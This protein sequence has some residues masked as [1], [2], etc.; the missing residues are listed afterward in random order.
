MA[1]AALDAPRK[2]QQHL[3]ACRTRSRLFNFEQ[4]KALVRPLKFGK[5]ADFHVWAKSC[6]RPL[7][8]P[9]A[10]DKFYRGRGWV[11]W[12]DALGYY[13]PSRI[14]RAEKAE[15]EPLRKEPR[16][17]NYEEALAW[18]MST[19]AEHASDYEVRRLPRK[20]QGS[21]FVRR[22][23][24]KPN[25]GVE[26]LWKIFLVKSAASKAIRA[27][28]YN[29]AAR[30]FPS[31]IGVIACCGR[32]GRAEVLSAA[33]LDVKLGSSPSSAQARF[34]LYHL[35]PMDTERGADSQF[36]SQFREVFA[37]LPEKSEADWLGQLAATDAYR[38]MHL[39]YREFVRDL[40][41]PAGVDFEV[42]GGFRQVY[43]LLLRKQNCFVT[44][45]R[46]H[47]STGKA[48]GRISR[49]RWCDP[50]RGLLPLDACDG[51]ELAF[52]VVLVWRQP[53]SLIGAYVFPRSWLLRNKIVRSV[54]SPGRI[55]ITL[56]PL[57]TAVRY[58]SCKRFYEDQ[59]RYYID[60][61]SRAECEVG[62]RCK[63]F[64]EILDREESDETTK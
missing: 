44:T 23:C 21:L 32:E 15:S 48:H 62:E 61:Q 36:L 60:F 24:C 6:K 64:R 27:S 43:N 28:Y 20:M 37:Q 14:R 54:S 3:S 5:R 7:R 4:F 42:I 49:T 8:I 26:S 1:L 35:A 16:S 46:I 11:S 9:L 25:E 31:D 10:P 55:S 17:A 53:L 51:A 57:R 52:V 29:F 41:E 40:V 63:K 30:D 50:A 22:R 45:A 2:V 39:L 34:N 12:M 33:K 47:E 58:A 13:Y 38:R 18:I 56:N 59:L 19:L